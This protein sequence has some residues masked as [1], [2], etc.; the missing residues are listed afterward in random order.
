LQCHFFLNLPQASKLLPRHALRQ[1][2]GGAGGMT[3]KDARRVLWYPTQA[4]VRLEWGTQ[5]SA[6]AWENCGSMLVG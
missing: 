5:R 3:K 4:K 1:A 6:A 2:T